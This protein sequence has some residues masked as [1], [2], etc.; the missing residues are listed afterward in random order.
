[1]AVTEED[2]ATGYHPD[3]TSKDELRIVAKKGLVVRLTQNLDK[4][5][6]FDQQENQTGKA[7]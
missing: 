5:R 6:G 2:L 7:R 4:Q 1:M 3:P